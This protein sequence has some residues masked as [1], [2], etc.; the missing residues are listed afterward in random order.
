MNKTEH[1]LQ[2][3]LLPVELEHTMQSYI[4]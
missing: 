3:Q 4:S 2:L 1:L